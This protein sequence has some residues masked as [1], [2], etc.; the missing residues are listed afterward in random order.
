MLIGLVGKPSSGKSSFFVSSTLIDIPISSRPFT[1]IE[2]NRGMGLVRV[3][4]IDKELG[5]QCNP[6]SGMCVNHV[7]FV[8]VELM[9]VAGLVPGAHEGKGLGSSFLDDL[10]QADVLIHVVDA[11]GST[12][13]EGNMVET[14]SHDPCM[15]IR[16][17][18]DELN[19][20]FLKVLE[21]NWG[22][23]VKLPVS[24]KEGLLRLFMEQLSGLSVKNFHVENALRKNNLNE[25]RL[26]DWTKEDKWN[27][28]KMLREIGKPIVIAANKCDMGSAK[29]NIEKMKSAFP[30]LTIIPC[31]AQ[32]E[33]ALKK[34]AKAGL[35]TYLPGDKQFTL[36][37]GLN[38][39]QKQ[40]L[41]TIQHSV[42]EPFGETGVQR[43]LETAV[44]DVLKFMAIFPA[45]T[46]GLKDKEGRVLPDCW[47]LP[48]ESTALDFAFT[49]HT[50]IGKSFI[51]AVNV[52]TKQMIGKDYVLSNRDA[53][54]I[55]AGK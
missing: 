45:S 21:K 41:E 42:M 15:D 6:R 16:F 14:G 20:W 55:I 47:L 38:D 19:F 51:R 3:D 8:P 25:K 4:C 43:V 27:F 32:A 35:I 37:E 1:T 5:T 31:S 52:R 33:L 13:S 26:P 17:L 36:K 12:D 7:R 28:V 10:R 18:E 23:M 53:I 49:I 54:E 46:K 40:A 2:P 29:A 9:D 39:A 48:P 34:A 22:K 44:F 11:S 30:N 24:G 50:D